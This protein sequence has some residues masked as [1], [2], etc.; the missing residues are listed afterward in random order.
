MLISECFY[1]VREVSTLHL[2]INW[3]CKETSAELLIKTT[4]VLRYNW[5]CFLHRTLADAHCKRVLLLPQIVTYLYVMRRGANRKLREALQICI[6]WA[7]FGF[8]PRV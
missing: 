6:L 5:S 2:R 3:Y 1:L 4:L 7:S 8:E